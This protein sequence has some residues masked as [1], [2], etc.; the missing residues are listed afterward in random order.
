MKRILPTDVNQAVERIAN[1]YRHSR[2]YTN[3]LNTDDAYQA[4]IDNFTEMLISGT[5]KSTGETIEDK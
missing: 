5:G 1:Y 2:L 4:Y 3:L